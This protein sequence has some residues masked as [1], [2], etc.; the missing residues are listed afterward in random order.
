MGGS[1]RLLHPVLFKWEVAHWIAWAGLSFTALCCSSYECWHNK[2]EPHTPS[3]VYSHLTVQIKPLGPAAKKGLYFLRGKTRV[4]L[5]DTTT[6]HDQSV[7]MRLCLH[8]LLKVSIPPIQSSSSSTVTVTPNSQ[9]F[10]N[11]IVV[12]EL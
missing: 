6:L 12:A 2:P 8:R 1:I 3:C 11:Q 9:V 7:W 4:L 5:R 10:G